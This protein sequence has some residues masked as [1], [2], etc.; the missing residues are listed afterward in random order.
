MRIDQAL[1]EV[2]PCFSFEFFPPKTD[3]GM[4]NLWRALTELREDDPTYV[5]VTY[6]AGGSTRGRTIDITKR[7]KSELGI[8]AMAHFTCVGATTDELRSTLDEMQAAGIENVLALRGDPPQGETEWRQT[9]GGLQYSTELARLIHENYDFAIGA[10]CFPE[11]H[12]ASP[13]LDHDLGVLKEKIAAGVTFVITQLFFD[14]ELY[15]EFVD[16]AR[17]AGVDVP[18]IPGIM[19]IEGYKQIKRITGMCGA[20]L[21]AELERELSIRQEDPD[22]V[23]DLGVAYATLQCSELLARGAPGIH[24]YTLNKSPATRA[25]LAALRAARP[26]DRAL[27]P[28]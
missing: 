27:Q 21:P 2:R 14:N 25:I 12:I 17:A 24:F 22:A 23:R 11:V 18:I 6:G 16:K 28:A 20:K 8:E 15:F 7:I 9:P 4:E 5:S 13:S 19:P 26:W 1:E 10:A 3:A